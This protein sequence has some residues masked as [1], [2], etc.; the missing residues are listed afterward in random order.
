MVDRERR[1]WRFLLK[2]EDAEL[3]CE[4]QFNVVKVSRTVNMARMNVLERT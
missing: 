1:S 2:E 3:G 4:N